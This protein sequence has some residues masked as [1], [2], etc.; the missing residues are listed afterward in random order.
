M[1]NLLFCI[2]LLGGVAAKT[3]TDLNPEFVTIYTAIINELQGNTTGR[4]IPPKTI[5]EKMAATQRRSQPNVLAETALASY[6]GYDYVRSFEEEKGLIESN[7]ATNSTFKISPNP[8]N[9]GFNL[10]ISNFTE[11]QVLYIYD[12]NSRLVKSVPIN[13]QATW[14]NTDYLFNGIYYCKL[15]LENKVEKLVIIK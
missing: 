7:I 14:I 3:K 4:T 10:F 12:V 6:F 1:I 13:S 2:S 11:P 5:L 15:S 8:T 9:G